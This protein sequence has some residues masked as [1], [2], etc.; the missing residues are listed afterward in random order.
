MAC[1]QQV[2]QFQEAQINAGWRIQMIPYDNTCKPAVIFNGVA[3]LGALVVIAGCLLAF[4]TAYPGRLPVRFSPRDGVTIG[5]AVAAGGF[6]LAIFG[7]WSKALGKRKDWE[8]V[9]ARCVDR[10]LKKILLPISPSPDSIST[11]GWFWRLVCE[12]EFR[13]QSYRVTRQVQWINF[14]SEAASMKFMEENVS[15]NGQCK[16]HVNPKN[17]LQTELSGQGLRDKFLY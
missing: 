13:G 2:H 3:S 5:L 1:K 8:L 16:L 4:N 7:V 12:Y 15:T 11:L 17:P 14:N 6:L 9:D 10:E